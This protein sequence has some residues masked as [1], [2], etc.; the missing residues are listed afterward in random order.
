MKLILIAVAAALILIPVAGATGGG[1]GHTPVTVCHKPGTPAEQELTFDDDGLWAHLRHGDTLGPCTP[2][3]DPPVCPEGTKQISEQGPLVCLKTET[4]EVIKEVPVEVVKVEY[5]DVPGPTQYVEK[6]VTVEKVVE[7]KIPGKTVTKIVKV[8]GKTKYVYRTKIVT[9]V[10][11]V[12]TYGI[13]KMPN[14]QLAV[15]GAG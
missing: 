15:P 14:G 12:P 13:C 8:K 10:K 6:I 5:R 2:P 1:E 7:V 11:M 3:V 4:V 9:K